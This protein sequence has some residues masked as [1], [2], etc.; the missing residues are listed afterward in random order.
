LL[1]VNALCEFPISVVVSSDDICSADLL[2]KVSLATDGNP[3]VELSHCESG[4]RVHSVWHLSLDEAVNDIRGCLGHGLK[5]SRPE[6][7]YVTAP[8]FLE[9]IM[10]VSVTTDED[11]IGDVVGHLNRRRGWILT[12]K[13]SGSGQLVEADVPLVELLDWPQAMARLTN[14][15]AHIAVKFRGYERAPDRDPDPPG[16][17]PVSVA[18]RA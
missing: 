13:E 10:R 8:E 12:I 18:K 7:N 5:V 17:E 4:V 16:K 15:R 3:Q 1:H 14:G 9:P 11:W 6:V 2:Q